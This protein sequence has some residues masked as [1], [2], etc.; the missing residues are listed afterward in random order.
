MTVTVL[1]LY[2]RL[3]RLL[4]VAPRPS[5]W[6]P[7]M[8]LLNT[9]DAGVGYLF[10]APSTLSAKFVGETERNRTLPLSFGDSK[11]PR[12][13]PALYGCKRRDRTSDI[14]VNSRMLC[15]LSYLALCLVRRA[16]VEPA[17]ALAEWV[18]A[19][20]DLHFSMPTDTCMYFPMTVRTQQSTLL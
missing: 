11:C 20:G 3:E 16:G 7:E 6:K 18:T 2:R 12:T 10:H 14:P 19:T 13:S 17:Q 9:T 1:A 5:G 8:L 4:G 15:R